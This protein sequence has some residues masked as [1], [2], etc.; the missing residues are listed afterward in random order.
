MRLGGRPARA[1]RLLHSCDTMKPN[2]PSAS[3]AQLDALGAF[4]LKLVKPGQTIGL[5]TG[6]AASA[7]IRALGQSRI[8]VRGVATSEASA[9]LARSMAIE[10]VPLD[11][12]TR[13]DTDFDG[14]DEVDSRL[15]LVKGFGGALVR[16]RIVAASA[17]KVVILVGAE[18]RVARLGARGR[19]PVEVVPFA[20]PLAL[21]RIRALGMR[22][23]IRL[24][25][26]GSEFRSDNGNA[27]LDCGVRRIAGAAR[28]ERDLRAIPGLVG[29]G[30]FLGIA[31]LVLVANPDGSIVT[32]APAR[33]SAA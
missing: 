5:G 9:E 11:A 32:M 25:P 30:L 22:P 13:I 3:E 33:R 28:L 29:T 24:N 21:R 23:A 26:D 2:A 19:I 17:R 16:E 27:I 7:F 10:V 1:A 14:A 4:A 18:K 6:R 31:S 15:N 12:K 8:K 20:I